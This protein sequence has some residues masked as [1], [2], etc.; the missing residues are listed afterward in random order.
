MSI[1]DF[2]AAIEEDAERIDAYKSRAS[3]YMQKESW[4]DAKTDAMLALEKD[5]TDYFAKQ[6]RDATI[7]KL[8]GQGT[9]DTQALTDVA[10]LGNSAGGAQSD[11]GFVGLSNQGAT[12]YLNSLYVFIHEVSNCILFCHFL[13]YLCNSIESFS[14]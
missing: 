9:S 2:T 12:C 5:P 8:F 4:D 3:A 7:Q 13:S 6:I 11:T 14:Q 10:A 1:A